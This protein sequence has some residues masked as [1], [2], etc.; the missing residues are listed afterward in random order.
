MR[1]TTG[2]ELAEQVRTA[3]LAKKTVHVSSSG[4]ET[5]EADLSTDPAAPEAM[6]TTL[7]G[8]D[9]IVLSQTELYQRSGESNAWQRLDVTTASGQAVLAAATRLAGRLHPAA[10]IAELE[11]VGDVTVSTKGTRHTVTIPTSP[12]QAFA[13]VLTLDADHLPVS[14]EL[15]GDDGQPVHLAYSQ[16]GGAR[17]V[18]APPTDQKQDQA[19]SS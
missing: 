16:W 15:R 9:V 13:T 8:S 2:K 10:L 14:A 12:G 19:P 4:A 3:M 1:T 7:D 5:A 11:R 17:P 18:V 6:R